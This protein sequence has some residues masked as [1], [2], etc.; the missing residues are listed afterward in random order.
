MR[1]K[2]SAEALLADME[3]L[4]Y[5]LRA[6]SRAGSPTHY[7][8]NSPH[9]AEDDKWFTVAYGQASTIISR[10]ALE[11]DPVVAL[12]SYEYNLARL[13]AVR[14]NVKNW[15]LL[16]VATK[17]VGST[18]SDTWAA[19]DIMRESFPSLMGVRV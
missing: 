17:V 16:E 1:D 13:V 10:R 2:A 14:T 5:V 8:L 19:D 6:A 11:D 3:G 15:D 18:V 9:C 12:N 7:L 4:C